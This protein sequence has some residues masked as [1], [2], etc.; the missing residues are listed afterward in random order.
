[1]NIT[2]TGDS[3]DFAIWNINGAINYIDTA[4]GTWDR[5]Y[6]LRITSRSLQVA[7]HNGQ[8][9]IIINHNS[10]STGIATTE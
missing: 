1:L 10:Q 6:E 5:A 9:A 3:T 8:G 7:N 4:G 2:T